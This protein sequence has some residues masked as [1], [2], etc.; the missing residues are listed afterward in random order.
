M[1]DLCIL[2]N[3]VVVSLADS[4]HYLHRMKAMDA[5]SKFG[6]FS[7]WSQLINA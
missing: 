5:F 4:D 3:I 1:I 7:F 6:M 2:L